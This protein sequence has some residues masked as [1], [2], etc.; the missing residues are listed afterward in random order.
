VHRDKSE[1]GFLRLFFPTGARPQ[2]TAIGD[3]ASA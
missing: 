2:P 1:R 3:G